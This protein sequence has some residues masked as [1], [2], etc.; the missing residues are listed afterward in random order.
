MA[1]RQINHMWV[2]CPA[3]PSAYAG[4]MPSKSSTFPDWRRIR[5]EMCI[6]KNHQLFII[7]S[8]HDSKLDH[9]AIITS[10]NKEVETGTYTLPRRVP[11]AEPAKPKF[12]EELPEQS[13]PSQN[14]MKSCRSRARQA[15]ILWRVAGAEPAKP[16]FYE[17]LPEQT[18]QG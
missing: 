3:N 4:S 17:E 9:W 18:H 5:L 15:K 11:G 16:K 1:E 13:P 7:R 2:Q 8:S 6:K 14:F 10:G 12:Y